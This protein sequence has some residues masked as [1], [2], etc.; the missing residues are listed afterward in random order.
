MAPSQ[1]ATRLLAE[2]AAHAGAKAIWL[3]TAASRWA[4]ELVLDRRYGSC[5][6][7]ESQA[8]AAVLQRE[9]LLPLRGTSR[10]PRQAD[11]A[12]G[13]RCDATSHDFS[14]GASELP[15]AVKAHRFTMIASSGIVCRPRQRRRL[16]PR[17]ADPDA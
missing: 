13:R 3:T 11:Q 17:S 9:S 14:S 2:V 5:G 1:D 16:A 8:Q 7:L 10:A 15:R 4:D 6:P 12:H